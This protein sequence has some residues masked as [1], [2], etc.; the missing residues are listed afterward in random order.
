MTILLLVFSCVFG[1][2]LAVPIGLVQVTGPKPLAWLASGF[3]TVIRGTPLLIQLYLLYYGL[4]T[5]FPPA[6]HGCAR[7]SSGR[8]FA[9]DSL[10]RPL[11]SH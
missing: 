1:M 11:P 6:F 3:C 9:R 4:G 5:L 8:C 2:I 7:A 10:T